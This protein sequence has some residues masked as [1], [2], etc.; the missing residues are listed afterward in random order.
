MSWRGMMVMRS[1]DGRAKESSQIWGREIGV[2]S[3]RTKKRVK[4]TTNG[5]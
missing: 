2:M 1:E 3:V 5:D 4:L